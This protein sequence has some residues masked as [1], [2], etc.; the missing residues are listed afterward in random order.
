MQGQ[1]PRLSVGA[2][3]SRP[4][5]QEGACRRGPDSAVPAPSAGLPQETEFLRSLPF[6]CSASGGPVGPAMGLVLG[7]CHPGQQGYVTMDT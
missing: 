5:G 6:G 2:G 1:T 4:A 7:C 3:G